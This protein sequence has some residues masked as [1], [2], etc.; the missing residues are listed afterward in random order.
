VTNLLVLAAAWGALLTACPTAEPC[1]ILFQAQRPRGTEDIY[2]FRIRDSSIR[3]LV[4]ADTFSSRSLPAWSPNG[5]SIAF[6][7][8][9]GDT[10][11]L[12]V[13]DSLSGAPRHIAAGLGGFIAFPDWSPDGTQLLF[14]AGRH[15]RYGVY[16]IQIDGSGLRIVLQDPAT[17]RSPSWSPHGGEFA[18][19]TYRNGRSEILIVNPA[20]G[21]RRTVLVLDSA[22]ADFPQW[23]PQGDELLITVYRGTAGLYETRR[24]KYGS[25]LALLDLRTQ[26]LRAITDGHGLNNYGRWSRDGRWIAFQSNRQEGGL[27][28]S[29]DD[30]PRYETLEL[31]IIRRDGTGLHR[32]TTNTYFDGHP[33]W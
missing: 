17:Y 16:L 10:A 5:R 24:R 7:R 9:F 2:A 22:Y 4:H 31:Y 29:T 20:T 30:S 8:E 19:S 11:Q 23:S 33:S 12:Y 3:R 14:S 26:H 6:T 21:A 28:D 1:D 32:P 25:N 27:P 18:V 15:G 13:L